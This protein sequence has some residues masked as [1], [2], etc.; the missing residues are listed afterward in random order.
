MIC[1]LVLC[2]SQEGEAQSRGEHELRDGRRARIKS[3]DPM[4]RSVT[5]CC[6]NNA[7]V[8]S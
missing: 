2:S 8:V 5:S 4:Q 3:S 7:A 6:T 1:V